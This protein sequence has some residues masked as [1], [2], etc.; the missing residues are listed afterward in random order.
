MQLDTLYEDSRRR[1][2][3][4]VAEAD[5]SIPVPACPGWT[6]HDVVAHMVGTVHDALEGRLTGP[7]SDEQPAAQVAR[8]RGRDTGGLLEEWA[9]V[10]G[11]FAALI[12]EFAVWPGVIDAVSHEQDI[13]GALGRPG[14]RESDGVT[15]A[16]GAL[17]RRW[18]PPVPIRIDLPDEVVVA[19]DGEP[20]IALET[21]PW[22]ILR[23]R[24]GRRSRAQLAAL[25]WSG[26]PAPVLDH[27]VV[28]GPAASDLIE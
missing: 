9:S 27:L 26:D 18:Q 22:E 15:A 5:T 10:S 24:M 4:V 17:L 23:V 19:G 11:R 3:S 16:S 2:T 28:F 13:R 21:T 14:D 7:P 8:Y 1:I 12:N 25:A 20:G 6:I